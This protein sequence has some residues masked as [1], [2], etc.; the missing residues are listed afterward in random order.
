[1]ETL[2]LQSLFVFS[3]M[4]LFALCQLLLRSNYSAASKHN[5]LLSTVLLIPFLPFV[6][7]VPNLPLYVLDV[8]RPDLL[9][10]FDLVAVPASMLP[11]AFALNSPWFIATLVIVYGV[12][13]LYSL[14]KIIGSLRYL[15]TLRERANPLRD[16]SVLTE[17]SVLEQEIDVLVLPGLASPI[18]FGFY[19]KTILIPADLGVSEH[20]EL[21]MAILHELGHVA[22][23]DSAL[24]LLAQCALAFVWCHPLIPFVRK[25]L[26]LQAELATDDHVLANGGCVQRYAN[27]LLF[28][29]RRAKLPVSIANRKLIMAPAF[30]TLKTALEQRVLGALK[31]ALR[32]VG[33][34]R[35]DRS[36]LVEAFARNV[37]VVFALSSLQLSAVSADSTKAGVYIE[38]VTKLLLVPQTE[39]RIV[40]ACPTG[41]ALG[42][43]QQLKQS[44]VTRVDLDEQ[45]QRSTRLPLGLFEASLQT[46]EVSPLQAIAKV[47][48][49]PFISVMGLT[50]KRSVF[51]IY[52]ERALRRGIEGYVVVE[53]TIDE[54]GRVVE[55]QVRESSPKHMFDKATLRALK[56]YQ[57]T[58]LPSNSAQ[59]HGVQNRFV[60]QLG[61]H[62]DF[63]PSSEKSFDGITMIAMGERHDY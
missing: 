7:S 26:E 35:A 29:A 46:A 25:Q 56:Q 2:M 19:R 21:R 39:Q 28:F 47:D 61:S 1:M 27:T 17:L 16:H 34:E 58:R 11:S 62:D 44:P 51:P 6:L 54:R 60:F 13:V 37:L 43:P 55:P 48:F 10:P 45:W 40:I 52:P 5:Q 38:P 8:G 53:F 50:P 49:D 57:Y 36:K 24:R 15:G 23:S 18:T 9:P 32:P 30:F 41:V 33:R 31:G 20:S 59:V 12:G 63:E 22:R 4:L 42:R 14:V 3:C